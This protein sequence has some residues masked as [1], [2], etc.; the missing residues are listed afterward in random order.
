MRV[1]LSGASSFLGF[2]LAKELLDAGHEVFAPLRDKPGR[3]GLPLAGAGFHLFSGDMENRPG[4]G[5]D[6]AG[7]WTGRSRTEISRPRRT[8]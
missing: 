6:S 4:A 1:L 5:W 7:A 8:W 2:A 3:A